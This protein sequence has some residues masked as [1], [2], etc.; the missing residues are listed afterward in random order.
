VQQQQHGA[1]GASSQ[2]TSDVEPWERGMS[3]MHLEQQRGSVLGGKRFK[4]DTHSSLNTRKSPSSNCS[5][6]RPILT[7]KQRQKR[8]GKG[9]EVLQAAARGLGDEQ[10]VESAEEE[11]GEGTAAAS[12][13]MK[14]E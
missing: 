7:E 9:R 3:N 2:Q 8:K 6:N 10:P 5:S 1:M 14:R 12:N 4:P 11:E 13:L